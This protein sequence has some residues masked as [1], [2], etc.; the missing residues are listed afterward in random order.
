MGDDQASAETLDADHLGTAKFRSSQDPNY[1]TLLSSLT[2]FLQKE[3]QR[4]QKL[5]PKENGKHALSPA[6]RL[7]PPYF[8]LTPPECLAAILPPQKDP[9]PPAYPG[10]DSWPHDLPTFNSWLHRRDR[11][12]RLLWIQAPPGA[13]KSTLLRS[14]CARVKAQY[15]PAAA[16][17]SATA[18]G[19]DLD[20]VF[21][22]PCRA[23]QVGPAA[24]YRSLL[25]GLFPHDARLRRALLS[26]AEKERG[27]GRG[28]ELSDADAVTFFVEE[29]ITH[30]VETATRRTF[31]LV[32]ASDGCSPPYLDTLA[33]HLAQLARNSNFTICLASDHPTSSPRLHPPPLEISMR[34]H[35]A[36][37]ISRYVSLNLHA[38]CSPATA[39]KVASRSGGIFLW[40]EIV[41]NV[42]NAAAE[43]GAPRLLIE[44][45][46]GELPADLYG[47]YTWT[48]GTLSPV[49]R[50]DCLTL[51]QCAILS[52]E[53]IR[54]ED[55]AVAT[56]LTKPWC[57][58]DTPATALDLNPPSR[59]RFD[60]PHAFH[61]HMRSRSL[62]LLELQSCGESHQPLGL[63][64]VRAVHESVADFFLRGGG[65][66]CLA[67]RE[68]EGTSFED[69]GHYV[70][71]RACLEF[72]DMVD[73]AALGYAASPHLPTSSSPSP[74][75]SPRRNSAAPRHLT[76]PPFLRYAAKNLAYHL[77]SPTPSRYSLPQLP[78]FRLLAR[79][80]MRLYIRWT[81]LLHA[82]TPSEIL[83]ASES[84][85]E[86]LARFPA[87]KLGL[88]RVLRVLGRLSRQVGVGTGLGIQKGRRSDRGG[89]EAGMS[90]TPST[91]GS[92]GSVWSPGVVWTPLTPVS[93]GKGLA[94]H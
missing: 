65:Y 4:R 51:M 42:L 36:D 82:S 79:D 91:A 44:E 29:Y 9:P 52:P 63:R 20:S 14:L 18:E 77:L 88:E 17:V 50:A 64:R 1:K 49:E 5:E 23:K 81:A 61:R 73:L 84:A 27:L 72:L 59:I 39:H 78:L 25:G 76:I 85:Q 37:D 33:S 83:S 92:G 22:L 86:L 11:I 93:V 46:V 68:A 2:S 87:G 8:P 62:G 12:N 41:V 47:L 38:E 74:G 3:V 24:V 56:Q 15:G 75:V 66:A 35:N 34:D 70:L 21:Y 94:A 45:I 16:I 48:L 54:L 90:V 80:N 30:R 60:T 71:S 10:T 7:R 6:P 89:N 69:A 13:G 43:E 57:P 31:I 40:A 19:R 53:P 28:V 67:G 55:L 32:D 26:L 58:G